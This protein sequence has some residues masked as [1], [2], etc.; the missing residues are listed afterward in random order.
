MQR[1]LKQTEDNLIPVLRTMSPIT[2]YPP[3][4]AM[5]HI[6]TRTA[7]WG[8]R[9]KRRKWRSL[10]Q[11]QRVHAC[12]EE[13]SSYTSCQRP[14]ITLAARFEAATLRFAAT[15]SPE[16][17]SWCQSFY[18]VPYHRQD[19]RYTG[20]NCQQGRSHPAYLTVSAVLRELIL[21]R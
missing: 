14:S 9:D 18:Y 19:T 5:D 20:H 21:L 17:M 6:Y 16:G 15:S 1:Q 13:S 8:S 3:C 11:T 10:D 7:N 2:Q 12:R 4:S